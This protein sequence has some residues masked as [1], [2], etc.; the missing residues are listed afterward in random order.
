MAEANIDLAAT[1]ADR[2]SKYGPF[3]DNAL[4]S[5]GLKDV[6]KSVPGWAKLSADQQEALELIA[7]KI[8]R[9]VTGNPNYI[10]NWVDVAGYATIV[11]KAVVNKTA[12]TETKK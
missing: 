6:M 2:G 10:D 4:V 9:I 5:Q 1:L 8:S 3:L 12:I 7:M 11:A